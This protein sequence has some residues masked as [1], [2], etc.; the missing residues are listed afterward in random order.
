MTVRESVITSKNDEST[1]KISSPL[2]GR[3]HNGSPAWRAVRTR[4]GLGGTVLHNWRIDSRTF[5]E[6]VQN[7]LY[8]AFGDI[9]PMQVGL[10]VDQLFEYFANER[11]RVLVRV[12]D[13][14]VMALNDREWMELVMPTQ[15]TK[16]WSLKVFGTPDRE[17]EKI[18]FFY[19]SNLRCIVLEQKIFFSLQEVVG[20]RCINRLAAEIS[21]QISSSF[22]DFLKQT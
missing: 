10:V 6:S 19:N 17:A 13:R 1:L 16:R 20:N 3:D 7:N 14:F 8:N 15:N 18:G 22:N 9:T 11:G 5:L 4:K 21:N 2:L 12:D